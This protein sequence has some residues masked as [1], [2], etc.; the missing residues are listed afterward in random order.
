MTT[1]ETCPHCGAEKFEE[2]SSV[3]F[4][5]GTIK[6]ADGTCLLHR[7]CYERQLAAKDVEIERLKRS[8]EEYQFDNY[9][10]PQNG[11]RIIN[12]CFP[13]CGCDGAR[14]CQ[15]ENGASNSALSLNVE[16]RFQKARVR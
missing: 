11:D 2:L 5:C 1:N 6:Y 10:N 13:D 16:L 15:A 3:E 9:G 12:C 14:H 7:H 4:L 8:L